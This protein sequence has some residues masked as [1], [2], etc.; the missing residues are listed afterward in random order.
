MVVVVFGLVS[1][2]VDFSPIWPK[3]NIGLIPVLEPVYCVTFM[4]IAMTV[5][6]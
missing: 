5:C 1:G 4:M 6:V 3:I 2:D